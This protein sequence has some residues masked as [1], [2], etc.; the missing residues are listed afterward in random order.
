MESIK[1]SN[2]ENLDRRRRHKQSLII[3]RMIATRIGGFFI[4]S[5]DA[6]KTLV[7]KYSFLKL[8]KYSSLIL[9][10]KSV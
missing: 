4:R 7:E 8:P 9:I 10:S 6:R 3:L 5:Q 1:N 2:N